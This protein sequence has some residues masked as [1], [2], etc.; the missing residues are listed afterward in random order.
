MTLPRASPRG[1]G[2][3]AA[4]GVRPPTF[5]FFVNDAKMFPEGYM[6]YLERALREN[7][8][9]KGTPVKLLLRGKAVVGTAGAE[10]AAGGGGGRK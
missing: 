5:V 1:A 2:G 9:F 10:A 6:R 8:G 4:Q 7:V 3:P